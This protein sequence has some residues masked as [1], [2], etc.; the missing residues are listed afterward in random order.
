M[1][2]ATTK[3][4]VMRPNNQ[5]SAFSGEKFLQRFDFLRS[6]FLFRNHVIEAKN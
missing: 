4:I 5:A 2:G 1:D 6:S 3:C